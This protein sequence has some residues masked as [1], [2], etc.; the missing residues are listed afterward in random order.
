ME[1]KVHVRRNLRLKPKL[2]VVVV[3]NAH[4][5]VVILVIPENNGCTW[6]SA[7][8]SKIHCVLVTM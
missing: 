2:T 8:I 5:A 1:M 6:V 7:G 4:E 3:N